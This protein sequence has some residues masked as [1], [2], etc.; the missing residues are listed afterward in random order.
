ME[1]SFGLSGQGRRLDVFAPCIL[2][3]IVDIVRHTKLVHIADTVS[4]DAEIAGSCH[5]LDVELHYQLCLERDEQDRARASTSEVVHVHDEEKQGVLEGLFIKA[6]VVQG[7]H[8]AFGFE[9]GVELDEKVKSRL[10]ESL[11]V[12]NSENYA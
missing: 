5:T 8:K 2:Q 4:L 1:D 12:T 10:N 6:W 3:H 7:G 9:P 11:D